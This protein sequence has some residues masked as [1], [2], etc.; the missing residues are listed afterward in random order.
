MVPVLL[1]PVHY[2]TAQDLDDTLYCRLLPGQAA[3]SPVE[4]P[5]IGRCIGS[6]KKVRVKK[7][8]NEVKFWLILSL[9]HFE[10]SHWLNWAKSKEGF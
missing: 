3:T 4:N 9:T 8:S 6:R 10:Q 1:G 5:R 7:G 2:T